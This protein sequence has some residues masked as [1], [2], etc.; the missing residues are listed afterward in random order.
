MN[1]DSTVGNLNGPSVGIPDRVCG[2]TISSGK[3]D[4]G[5]QLRSGMTWELES[6]VFTHLELGVELVHGFQNHGHDDEY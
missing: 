5:F 4:R 2:D 3:A 6:V 1:E